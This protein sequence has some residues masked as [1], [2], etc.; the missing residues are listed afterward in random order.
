MD[1]TRIIRNE[2][3]IICIRVDIEK[4]EEKAQFLAVKKDL[5]LS[6]NTEVFRALVREAYKKI[7]PTKHMPEV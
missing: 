5:G 6:I 2:S 7:T 1:V 4:E 3:Q